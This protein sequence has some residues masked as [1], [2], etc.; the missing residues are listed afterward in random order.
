MTTID[1]TGQLALAMQ[2]QLAA[3]RERGR[4][5]GPSSAHAGA[6]KDARVANTAAQ[7]IALISPDDEDRHRKAVRIFLQSELLREF[8]DG[9]LNDPQFG[10]MLDAVQEQMT[11][12]AVTAAAVTA[13]GEFLLATSSRN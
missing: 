8:G 4:A 6:V 1:P 3:L 9:L 12:D 10:T 7:R 2:A 11:Q 13:L 5:R